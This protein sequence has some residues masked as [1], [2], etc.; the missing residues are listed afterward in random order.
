[1]KK[2][3]FVFT[4]FA[5]GMGSTSLL[6]QDP[7]RLTDIVFT[8]NGRDTTQ[9]GYGFVTI[10]LVFDSTMDNSVAPIIN[11]SLDQNYG[12][13]FP[14]QG[15][16]QNAS[17]W[18]GQ[19]SITD[20]V[21]ATG[22][23]EYL[24]RISGARDTSGVV[25]NPAFSSDINN[26]TLFICRSG[27]ASF[28][29]DSLLF[30]STLQG[31]AND[32][33]LV[34]YNTSCATLNI[35][36]FSI[37]SPFSIANPEF[38]TII[39]ANDSLVLTVRFRPTQRANYLDSLMFR[40]NDRLQ[41]DHFVYVSGTGV[42]PNM[43][44][45][46]VETINFG[47]VQLDSSTTRVLRVHNQPA[48]DTLLSGNL[49]IIRITPSIEQVFSVDRSSFTVAP[50]DTEQ[51]I[52]TFRPQQAI[53]Y[54]NTFLTITS[55]DSANASYRINL[56]GNAEDETPPRPVTNLQAI[57][58]GSSGYTRLDSLRICWDNPDDPSGIAGIFWK[59]VTDNAPPT[60]PNDTTNGGSAVPVLQGNR[61]C[62]YLPLRGR[63]TSSGRW[64]CYVWL[65]DGR[66]NS[67]YRNAQLTTFVYDVNPPGRPTLIAQS[68]PGTRW[69]GSN[70]QFRITISIPEDQQRGFPDA[71][72]LRW[73]FKAPPNS[74]TD[75]IGR[76]VFNAQ[77]IDTATVPIPFL[78]NTLCGDDS[79]YFWL[80]DSA[81]NSNHE[82]VSFARY[83]F[84][85]CAPQ[86]TRIGS[87][88]DAAQL[89][90]DFRETVVITD[91]V[92]VDSAWFE[93]RFGGAETAEPSRELMQK[94]GTDTFYVDLRGAG[95][96]RRG[97]EYRIMARDSL[98]NQGNGP[99]N[100][101]TCVSGS[102][103]WYPIP[104]RVSGNGDFRIDTQGNAVPLLA[105]TDSTTYQLV[106]VPY[107]L[108]SSGVMNVL[109][110]DLGAYDDNQWR[111]FDYNNSGTTPQ[112]L[113]GS[114]ARSFVPGRSF[115]IITRKE[116]IVVDSGPGQ[117]VKTVCPDSIRLY[118]GWNLI[119]TPFN[120]PVHKNSLRLIN[121]RADTV[122][123]RSY[124]RGWNIVDLME[125]WRGYALYVTRASNVS[126]GTPIWLLVE[127]K[128]AAGR[129]EKAAE[130][131]LAEEWMIRIS[132][133]AGKVDDKD[134]WLGVRTFAAD[135][136]D[137]LELA[138]PPVV[139]KY[140]SVAFPRAEWN[141]PAR[142]F[143]TDFRAT[144]ARDFVWEFSIET[145]QSYTDIDVDFE[146]LGA[147]PGDAEI[148]LIDEAAGIAQNLGTSRHYRFRSGKDGAHKNLKIVIGSQ[149]YAQEQAGE[150]A[151]V[152]A[153]FELLQNY[154][155]PFN[156]ETVIRY[157]LPQAATVTIA[158]YNQLGQK[159]RTLV[160]DQQQNAG[161]YSVLWN[162]RDDAG[163]RAASGLYL[164]RITA[165]EQALTRK[166]VLMK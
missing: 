47:K 17:T 38:N 71:S 52:V 124:E 135:G 116:N 50:G 123:L 160:S 121:A 19:V 136:F 1:M 6:A 103:M 146:M 130:Q 36:N 154:P 150:I 105:G 137:D 117:T 55:N 51:V 84:D 156:P 115:F 129:R 139:G 10:E 24:F 149:Q 59:F 132:A 98:G 27:S 76:T 62:V 53:N 144:G 152:P 125:P 5:V 141:Q 49:S 151:L 131:L 12:L 87:A 65:V 100:D 101:L 67:G 30:G 161:Y 46:P 119:A 97:I 77:Q 35:T 14:A 26:T 91:D 128:A 28:S 15:G 164:Y 72:E 31:V 140:V 64:N 79:V 61:Y 127:P 33:E 37:P 57:W 32:R 99:T 11:F 69:F 106:S 68:I 29:A 107:E 63:L 95:I 85:I 45:S 162:G 165:G 114:A 21:P 18:Q 104:T 73:K 126:P 110:D 9:V 75:F 111:L 58:G 20:I 44:T 7:P 94:T 34:I 39:P 145:N 48:A 2:W 25:M 82:N 89:G 54:T 108:D 147:V 120:F 80:A 4:I 92:P 159:V 142:R 43:V 16:W 155:N 41:A 74:A 93:Y 90:A 138:E 78:S 158:I 8:K 86:I 23:G 56:I 42:G 122:S 157:N 40:T 166:M 133:Q 81:G 13:T 163:R 3:L 66:G 113:E 109:S 148:F 143:S 70:S 153:A 88:S 118:E 22:D 60:S 112:W 96:T 134:N 102:D 83:R